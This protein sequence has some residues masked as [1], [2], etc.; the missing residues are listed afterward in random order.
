MSSLLGIFL[1]WRP[2]P[3]IAMSSSLPLGASHPIA[4][5]ETETEFRAKLQDLGW[6]LHRQSG[7]HLKFSLPTVSRT[8]APVRLFDF[9][10]SANNRKCPVKG[11]E[12]DA[13]DRWNTPCR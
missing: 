11:L 10:G 5:P 4:T 8:S 9:H 12:Q 7:G 6:S 1:L 2:G 13:E 3:V